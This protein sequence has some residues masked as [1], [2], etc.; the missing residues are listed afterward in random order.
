M[1]RRLTPE[2][3]HTWKDEDHQLDDVIARYQRRHRELGELMRQATEMYAELNTQIQ[4]HVQIASESLKR[5]ESTDSPDQEKLALS[6]K[7]TAD[8]QIKLLRQNADAL[9]ARMAELELE[10][11]KTDASLTKMQSGRA[12]LAARLKAAEPSDQPYRRVA[13]PV[14]ILVTALLVVVCALLFKIGPSAEI[15]VSLSLDQG[16]LE[17]E[18]EPVTIDQ[19]AAKIDQRTIKA[20]QETV[21]VEQEAITIDQST[22]MVNQGTLKVQIPD[23]YRHEVEVRAKSLQGAKRVVSIN[24]GTGW[25]TELREGKYRIKVNGRKNQFQ[26]D[27]YIVNISRDTLHLVTVSRMKKPVDNAKIANKNRNKNGNISD[28]G[29]FVTNGQV[30][31]ESADYVFTA[32]LDSDGDLDVIT[33]QFATDEKTLIWLNQGGLQGGNAGTFIDSG[34]NFGIPSI[35][36]ATFGDVD[37][38]DDVDAFFDVDHLSGYELWKNQGGMQGGTTGVFARSDQVLGDSKITRVVLGDLDQDGDL[39]VFVTNETSHPTIGKANQVW[40]NQDGV[41]VEGQPLGSS[42]SRD[43]ALGDL[44]GD[45]DLDAYIANH[46]ARGQKD[47]NRVWLNEGGAQGGTTGMF[48]DSGQK[49]GSTSQSDV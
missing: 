42:H 10:L 28:G 32:D 37:G 24:N 43:V 8:N 23:A 45:G 35:T 31:G 18:Q 4:D 44:D 30:L 2:M 41:F 29:L 34:K 49:L 40:V 9:K 26:L 38:D 5:A 48:S 17:A 14:I 33:S 27:K 13:T 3:V 46:N 47:A 15:P 39:D 16:T 36:N 19:E 20:D 22:L 21:A 12:A 11:S 25:E 7:R 1:V 6:K